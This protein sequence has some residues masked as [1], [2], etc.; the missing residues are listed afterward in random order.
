MKKTAESEAARLEQLW[1]GK[2]GDDYIDRNLQA[3]AHRGP[4]W[5]GLLAEFPVERVLEIGCNIGTNLQWIAQVIPACQVYG[6]DINVKS[7]K[8]LHQNTPEINA[9]WSPA[10]ELPFRDEWFDMV[11]TMG[12][13]IHQ[14]EDSLAGVLREMFR[15]SRKYLV[16][17]EYF[18]EETQE[19]LYHQQQGALFKRNYPKIF[20][21]FFPEL[22]LLKE[23]FLSKQ[24]GWDDVSYWVFAKRKRG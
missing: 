22:E 23:G 4:F 5:K 6:V 21:E 12:V 14:P 20:I 24:E 3:G 11:F 18:S 8:N 2:F 10:R 16:C 17:A 19:V 15:C 9:M 13:L 1:S 7:L